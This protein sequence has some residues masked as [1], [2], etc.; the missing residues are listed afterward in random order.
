MMWFSTLLKDADSL[1]PLVEERIRELDL[2]NITH[3]P[4]ALMKVYNEFISEGNLAKIL[5]GDIQPIKAHTQIKYGSFPISVVGF[6]SEGVLYKIQVVKLDS[7]YPRPEGTEFPELKFQLVRKGEKGWES[8]IEPMLDKEIL[9]ELNKDGQY[10][11]VEKG[12]LTL[13]NWDYFGEEFK[14]IIKNIFESNREQYYAAQVD[15]DIFDNFYDKILPKY[16]ELQF[17]IVPVGRTATP[18]T[19]NIKLNISTRRGYIGQHTA[20]PTLRRKGTRRAVM[21]PPS[22]FGIAYPSSIG[23]SVIRQ[24]QKHLTGFIEGH[25][26]Y[27]LGTLTLYSATERHQETAEQH[28]EEYESWF[29]Y[30]KNK[31]YVFS[32]YFDKVVAI[33]ISQISGRDTHICMQVITP[34]NLKN[35]IKILRTS[36]KQVQRKWKNALGEPNRQQYS[37]DLQDLRYKRRMNQAI[38]KMIEE[39]TYTNPQLPKDVSDKELIDYINDYGGQFCMYPRQI[40]GISAT[41]NL[42]MSL[43]GLLGALHNPELRPMHYGSERDREGRDVAIRPAG[44]EEWGLK[45]TRGR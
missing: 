30:S 27:L 3:S 29:Y 38:L 5:E 35:S 26:E 9:N 6:R 18:Y 40:P 43:Q 21:A 4:I 33:N 39:E 25:I 31:E 28:P 10:W 8:D 22:Q 17:V 24:L 15:Q 7:A 44:R 42:N 1:L 45:G 11:K 41:F 12:N 32:N 20:V 14:N 13:Q 36:I 16:I 19:L 34:D 2:A 37:Q 23:E